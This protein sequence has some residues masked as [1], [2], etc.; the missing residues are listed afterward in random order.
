MHPCIAFC[1]TGTFNPYAWQGDIHAVA[2]CS[3]ISDWL[4]TAGLKHLAVSVKKLAA[5]HNKRVLL[6]LNNGGSFPLLCTTY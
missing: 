5:G 3:G 2:Y 6:S 1:F 4:S